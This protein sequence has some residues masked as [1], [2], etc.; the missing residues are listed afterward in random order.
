MAVGSHGP[1]GG[2]RDALLASELAKL[3]VEARLHRAQ[4]GG[5]YSR[6]LLAE[7][8]GVPEATFVRWLS[9]DAVTGDDNGDL[10][11]VVSTLALWAGQS[12]PERRRWLLLAAATGKRQAT[13][14]KLKLSG[15]LRKPANWISG[16]VTAVIIAVAGAVATAIV[17]Q[18]IAP[19]PAPRPTSALGASSV[20]FGVTVS[21]TNGELSD[22][23]SWLFAQPIEK[24]PYRGLQGSQNA[25]ADEAWALRN[26]A[27]DV[28]GGAY[29][30]TLQGNSATDNVV[31]KDVRIEVLSR[32]AAQAGT[33]IYNAS[34]CGGALTAQDFTVQVDSSDPVFVA[35]NRATRWPYTISSSDTE[36]LILDA[37]ISPSD[38]D[39]YQFVYRIDWSQG[40]RQGTVTVPAPNGKPFTATPL[41]PGS[42]TYHSDNGH[43]SS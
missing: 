26:G 15:L 3:E 41:L 10:M 34:G 7:V 38:R 36:Y 20:P 9:G 6:F 28:N 23:A 8:S 19:S 2:P 25:A 11:A 37:Q 32:K 21:R 4:A 14:T 43:W 1:A 29:T 22:C 33:A 5:Q 16:I 30:I 13:G 40:S 17:M 12:E 39:E 18:M 24:I 35:Q 42:M 27:A 31:I